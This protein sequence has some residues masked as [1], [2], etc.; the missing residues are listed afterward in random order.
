MRRQLPAAPQ[1]EKVAIDGPRAFPILTAFERIG[2]RPSKGYALI[3]SGEL[4]TFLIGRN[5]Y[6][7]AEA[8]GA[9]LQLCVKRSMFE[10]PDQRGRKV[11]AGVAASL[12][13]RGVAA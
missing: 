1:N 2:V 9:F 7:T 12:A 13:A 8:I 11:A 6:A 5:R 10:T 4:E 3:A